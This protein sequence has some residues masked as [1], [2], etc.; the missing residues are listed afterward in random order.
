MIALGAVAER[1]H[2]GPL[3]VFAFVWSTLVYS[4]IARWTWNPKGWSAHLGVLD[5][6]GGTPVHI[7]S[8]ATALALS[9]YLGIRP[10]IDLQ[11][12]TEQCW[13]HMPRNILD[14]VWLVWLQRRLGPR[15]KF[16]GG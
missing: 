6:A 3:V 16:P 12:S 5:Y 4:P 9:V 1:A 2:L 15:C 14:M 10:G 13:L 7:T 8:G 11:L